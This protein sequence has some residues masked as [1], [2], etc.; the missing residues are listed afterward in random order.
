MMTVNEDTYVLPEDSDQFLAEVLP[1]S[2]PLRITW[3]VL[4]TEEKE[5]YLS[6]A[7]RNIDALT[8]IGNKVWCYQPLQFPRIA[9][10][11]PVDYDNAPREVKRAQVYWAAWIAKD[12]LYVNRRNNDAC[13][14]LGLIK[15][16]TPSVDGVPPRVKEI[17]HRWLTNWR[18]V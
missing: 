10:G 12:E 11:Y 18:K 15:E 1:A 14:A 6:S 13:L 17:L 2:N 7:L 5:G 3:E 16:P 9:R 8:F 4:S